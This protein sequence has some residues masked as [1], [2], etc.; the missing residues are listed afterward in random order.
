MH[1]AQWIHKVGGQAHG[2]IQM[3]AAGRQKGKFRGIKAP[4]VLGR[5]PKGFK[6]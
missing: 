6:S 1:N 3:T 2:T 4:A 5:P